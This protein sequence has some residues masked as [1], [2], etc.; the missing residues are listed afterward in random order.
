MLLTRLF[1]ILLAVAVVSAGGDTR[2][3]TGTVQ[4]C[5][6]DVN[7]HFYGQCAGGD[8]DLTT[9]Y[10]IKDGLFGQNL[11]NFN[12]KIA[13]FRLMTGGYYCLLYE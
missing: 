1:E 8:V 3:V 11:G 13:L 10:D 6:G 2:P 9:C 7:T 4:F 5:E 12:D